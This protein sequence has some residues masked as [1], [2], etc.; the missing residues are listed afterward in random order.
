MNDKLNMLLYFLKKIWFIILIVFIV[1]IAGISS[2]EIYRE[3]VLNINPDVSYKTS[4]SISLSCEPLDSLNPVCSK[5]E[6]MYYLSKLIYNSLFDYDDTLNIVPELVESYSVDKMRGKV[7]LKLKEGITWHNGEPLTAK[8]INYTVTAFHAAGNTSLHYDKTSRISYVYV[9]GTHE[10]E[11]YFRNAYD[12]S[13]DDLTFPILPSSQYST[14]Y[15]LAKAKDGFHPV[16][17]GQYQ[18]Q[19]YNYLKQLRLKPNEAYWDNKA[20]KKLKI[21]IL[22]EK[23]LSSNMLQIESVTCYM[24]MTSE[25]KSTVIDR[26]FVMYDLISNQVE[27]LV[28]N[29]KSEV[30]KIASMRKAVAYAIH[31]Q[32]VLANGYMNDGVLSD[33]IYYPNFCGV[34][35]EG[36]PYTFNPEKAAEI[37]KKQGYRDSDNNGILETEEEE[38]LEISIAVNKNNSSRL[39]AARVIQKNLQN[40][41]IKTVL[42][43]LTWEDYQKA[44]SYGKHD[45]IVTGYAVNE[46]YDLRDFFNRK[47]EWGY[48]NEKLFALAGEME[49]LHTAEEYTKLYSDMKKEL[50][51]ELPYYSLCY[52]K[53]GLVGIN[54][55]EAEKMPVFH[56]IYRN[57]DTWSWTYEVVSDKQ[58]NEKQASVQET[59]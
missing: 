52:K 23:E 55:F 19:S 37:L 15:Q 18:Y 17:T 48:Y 7:T 53:I 40:A 31:E 28:F 6:D 51:D 46:Q 5:S 20:D 33:T 21:M 39:A 11:I 58:A 10:A 38:E 12:A 32:D 25:R 24:D 45:I 57:I 42:D 8:D 13:L 14:A 27:F 1:L 9:R 56:D 16:G 47:N 34:M 49:M 30:L 36:S 2:I 41:G 44:I 59:E 50:L 54:G 4:D 43:E 3:E 29:P 35:D 22:P 26:N